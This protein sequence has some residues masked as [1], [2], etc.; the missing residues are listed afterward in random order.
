M[1][2]DW[3]RYTCETGVTYACELAQLRLWLQ[4]IPQGWQTA[5]RHEVPHGF[6]PLRTSIPAPSHVERRRF[7]TP[8][9]AKAVRLVPV[10]PDRSVVSRPEERIE[11]A[12][13]HKGL[14]FVTVPVWL[15]VQTET[16][17]PI[18]LG[19]YPT[20]LL[21]KTWFG[22]P[23]EDGEIGYALTTR[24]RQEIASLTDVEGRAICPVLIENHTHEAMV[25]AQF[26]LSVRHMSV[27]QTADGKL[28]TNECRMGYTGSLF[29]AS[30][31]FGRTA[32]EQAKGA[33]LLSEPRE[34]P[35]SG[36]TARVIADAIFKQPF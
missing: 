8:P 25:F 6:A 36:L 16:P 19:D 12:P 11:I 2:F 27:Y 35:S 5:F 32:P 30:I 21:S 34:A 9:D 18:A 3:N 31:T 26:L 4:R 1:Q 33:K 17:R 28:W 15:R 29:P 7:V 20:A 10:L 22:H 23:A 14:F 13:R 24:A